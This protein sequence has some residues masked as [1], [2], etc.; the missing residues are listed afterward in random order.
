MILSNHRTADRGRRT[1]AAAVILALALVAAVLLAAAAQP[2]RAQDAGAPWRMG[3]GARGM[4]LGNALAADV[5]GRASPYYNPALAPFVPRQHLTASMAFMSF[6]RQMQFLQFAA[7]VRP[8]A[9]VASG[10]VYAGV[11]DIQGR[12]SSGAPTEAFSS[13]AY[14][15][16]LTFGTRIGSRLAAGASFKLYRAQ[17]L[18]EADAARGVGVDLGL[19][20]RLTRRL[21]VA[22]VAGDLLARYAWDTADLYG[23]DGRLRTDTFPRRFRLGASYQFAEGRAWLLAEAELQAARRERAEDGV[24]EHVR[25]TRARLGAAYAPLDGFTLHA[26]LDRLGARGGGRGLRPAAGFAV[27]RALGQ[28]PLRASYGVVYE[29]NVGSAMHLIAL[30]L[31][32]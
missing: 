4:A 23:R 20:A 8:R 5:S 9:G 11:D 16:F 3:F 6:D 28:L 30:T 29:A 24:A 13:E 26:G 17:L 27:D 1:A 2:A 22:F 25:S 19:V 7:P 31:F 14:A 32:L 15:F 21:H 12:N 10:I 18:A